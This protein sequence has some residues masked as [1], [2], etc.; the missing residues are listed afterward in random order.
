MEQKSIRFLGKKVSYYQSGTGEKCIILLHGF[1]ESSSMWGEYVS[2]WNQDFKIIAIDLPGHGNSDS[3]SE[4]NSTI[5]MSDAVDAVLKTENILT[6]IFIGHSMGGYVALAFG[7]R[8]QEKVKGVILLNSTAFADSEIKKGDRDRA[9]KVM[10][11]NPSIFI[12]ESIPNLFAT[13]HRE[14][15][16]VDIK[17]IIQEALN[18]NIE[19]ACACLL[20]MKER[21]DK[22]K[23]LKENRFPVKFIVGAKDNVIPIDK[24]KEQIILHPKIQAQIFPESG[25]MSFIE[26]KDECFDSM[27][28]FINELV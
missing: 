24:V 10:R 9:I 14:K 11:K 20:G 28:A 13:D 3:L 7:E 5:L 23:L 18:T 6:A 16:E 27:K 12:N 19:G 1:L 26:A 22:T 17:R 15:Y 2:R 4:I 25:H 21:E 8:Y